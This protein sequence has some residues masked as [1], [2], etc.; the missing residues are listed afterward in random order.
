[1]TRPILACDLFS[2]IL[3]LELR[4]LQ[5]RTLPVEVNIQDETAHLDRAPRMARSFQALANLNAAPSK[6]ATAF[7]AAGRSAESERGAAR[8]VHAGARQ[9]HARQ[10]RGRIADLAQLERSRSDLGTC[11]FQRQSHGLAESMEHPDPGAPF[12]VERFPGA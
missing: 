5:R 11:L 2:S 1:M 12:G 3:D 8:A 6:F 9:S 10:S 7:G 4:G